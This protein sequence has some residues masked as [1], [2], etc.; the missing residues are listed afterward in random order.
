MIQNYHDN[1]AICRVFGPPDFFFTFTCNLKWPKIM[2]SF[3]KPEQRPSDKADVIIRVYH[4]K[5]EELINDIKL[6]K[7][8]G[9]CNAGIIFHNCLHSF[10]ILLNTNS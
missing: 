2:H 6:G 7:I 3:Y 4:M 1:I 8:F 5:L 9:R 10:T